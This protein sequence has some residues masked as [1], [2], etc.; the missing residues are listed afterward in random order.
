MNHILQII[1]SNTS[2]FMLLVLGLWAVAMPIITI[3]ELGHF[4]VG[5]WLG[6][7]PEVF[8][9]GFGK[10]LLKFTYKTT[11][12]RLAPIPLGGFVK[13]RVSRFDFVSNGEEV[14]QKRISAFRWFLISIAGPA[15]NFILCAGITVA[16]IF[17]Q[18]SYIKTAI[19]ISPSTNEASVKS[20]VLIFNQVP[21]LKLYLGSKLD[22]LGMVT[23]SGLS[24][25]VLPTNSLLLKES[26]LIPEITNLTLYER[27]HVS[28]LI[29]KEVI[30]A[31]TAVIADRD[32]SAYAS[33][34]SAEQVSGVIGVARQAKSAMFG[35]IFQYLV[36]VTGLSLSVGLFNLFPLAFLDG[37]AALTSLVEMVT[38]KHTS[39]KYY[40][41]YAVIS[42]IILLILL[43]L[44]IYNDVNASVTAMFKS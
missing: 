41:P 3:H 30:V 26:I 15:A 2:D 18:S 29:T 8:S 36:L 16:A 20:S 14:T 42:F 19:L 6:A 39:K 25:K 37:G 9:I 1:L 24:L 33:K 12:F 13:F 34:Q 5:K 21:I 32:K 22:S 7:D 28:F 11:E 27:M 10:A 40:V 38:R 23:T 44:G 35:G 31:L 17:Q 4:L 43:G